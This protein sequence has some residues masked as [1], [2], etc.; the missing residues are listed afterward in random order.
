[1]SE[2][3]VSDAR[4]RRGSNIGRP[5]DVSLL[6]CTQCRT[7]KLKCDRSRPC[8][9]RCIKLGDVCAYPQSRLQPVRRGNKVAESGTKTGYPKTLEPLLC[10]TVTGKNTSKSESHIHSSATDLRSSSLLEHPLCSVLIKHLISIYFDKLHHASPMLHRQ[11]FI[12]SLDLP[13][14]MQPPLFLQYTIMALAAA[15]SDT[16]R[17]L[18]LPFYQRAKAYANGDDIENRCVTLAHAQ[19]GNLMAK[20]EAEHLMF[21]RASMSLCHSVRIAQ[22]LNLDKVDAGEKVNSDLGAPNDWVELEERRRT[23]WA[24]F[25]CDHFVSATTKWPA[26]IH[27]QDIQTL[28]P[29]SD[30]AYENCCEEKASLLVDALHHGE[31]YSSFAGRVIAAHLFYHTLE[32]TFQVNS[33]YDLDFG[34]DPFWERHRDFDND[35]AIML[36]LLPKN[37][38][39]PGGF[40]SQNAVFVNAMLHAANICLHKAALWRALSQTV[41]DYMERQYQNRLL[42]AAEEILSIL[43][44]TPD[45]YATLLS[46]LINFSAYMA[47]VVFLEDVLDENSSQSEDN[48]E[49]MLQAMVAVGKTNAVTRSLAKQLVGEMV[50]HGLEF[51]IMEKKLTSWQV[52]DLPSDATMVPLLAK[53]DPRSPS[54]TFCVQS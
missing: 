3:T 46:P 15:S 7:R 17:H 14:H 31:G 19:Y 41:P 2:Q 42:P 8:C 37:L 13:T 52:K 49:F 28:L 22:I 44:M 26:L 50:Q 53:P 30:E 25:C 18:S 51:S 21:A 1:M 43:K 40:R 5:F 4:D 29:S 36:V 33:H 34:S 11:R 9:G 24:I 23:W 38:R 10:G 35:L 12:A 32:H 47:A 27:V 39:L 54:I 20:F 16:Y 45:I 6:S 48:L